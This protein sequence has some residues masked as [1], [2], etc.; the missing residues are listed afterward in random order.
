[1]FENSDQF[2]STIASVESYWVGSY[3]TWHFGG[4]KPVGR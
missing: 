4:A 1:M 3:L 2:A